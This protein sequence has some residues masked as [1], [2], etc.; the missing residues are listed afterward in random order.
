V[1]VEDLDSQIERDGLSASQIKTDVELRLR[2]N[3][4]KVD[5]NSRNYLDVFV[6]VLK[7]QPPG[8]RG[9]AYSI[10]VT[11]IQPALLER[12]KSPV[13]LATTW[14]AGV[15]GTLSPESLRDIRGFVLDY[16]D[17]FIN[18]YLAVNPKQ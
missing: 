7:A 1:L 9:Y 10:D 14:Q 6:K 3:G 5:D 12:D 4:I 15:L 8:P 11:V 17:K 13:P 16:V 2:R 18:D